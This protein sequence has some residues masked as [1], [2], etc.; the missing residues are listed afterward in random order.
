MKTNYRYLLFD[1]DHTL[2]DFTKD[3]YFAFQ[4]LFAELGMETDETFLNECNRLS[5]ETWTEVGLYNVYDKRVQKKYHRLYAGHL[6]TL[7]SKIFRLRPCRV[8]VR[9][10]ALRFLQ[11]LEEGGAYKDGAEECLKSLSRFFGG[12]YRLCVVTNGLKDIQRG[13]LQPFQKYLEGT[14]ISQELR[15]IKPDPEFF[16]RV[17]KK[18]GVR[19]EECLMI[20]DSLS[21][22][23]AGANAVGMDSVWVNFS[24]KQ[25]GTA[26][27][28]TYEVQSLWE[29]TELLNG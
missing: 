19:A 10:V 1:A 25:N 7:F 2:L 29:L 27:R 11:L 24:G 21:S 6:K 23:V 9:K 12:N 28:P 5:E 8:N 13:R 3:E 20:G 26:H 17:L 18:L 14:F 22:D 15:C 4:K 16:S